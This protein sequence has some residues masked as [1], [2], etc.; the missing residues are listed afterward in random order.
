MT[1]KVPQGSRMIDTDTEEGARE[2][3]SKY[4]DAGKKPPYWL[5]EKMKAMDMCDYTPADEGEPPP[6]VVNQHL[7]GY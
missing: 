2:L 7:D 1:L 5:V 6:Q 3:Y 4:V